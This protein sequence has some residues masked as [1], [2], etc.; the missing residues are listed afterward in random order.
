MKCMLQPELLGIALLHWSRKLTAR[1]LI[2]VT[3]I[4]SAGNLLS[5]SRAQYNI[6]LKPLIH[7]ACE[8]Y[9]TGKYHKKF[10]F[11]SPASCCAAFTLVLPVVK[12]FLPPL[13][14]TGASHG[15]LLLEV[16]H[17]STPPSH[18]L[19]LDLVGYL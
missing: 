5:R 9:Q 7:W 19:L 14:Y 8:T 17:P 11:P 4:T 15:A 10:L 18:P 6:E 13:H 2:T 1:I 12:R 16:P 3:P